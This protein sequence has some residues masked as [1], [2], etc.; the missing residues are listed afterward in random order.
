MKIFKLTKTQGIGLFVIVTLAAIYLVINF[1]KGEDIF[2]GRTRYYTTYQN[3]EGL[4]E[5]SPVFIRGLKVGKIDHISYDAVKDNFI[6]SFTIG[7]EYAVPANSVVEIYS[8]DLLGGKSIRINFGDTNIL[9]KGGDT[10]MGGIVPDMV[11]MLANEIGPV[12]EELMQLINNM[13]AVLANVNSVLDSNAKNDIAK[14]LDNLSKTLENTKG[15]TGNLNK[16]SPEITAV[17]ENLGKL[18]ASL[19]ESGEDINKSLKNINTITGKLS[20]AD[21]DATISSLK[22]LL[23]KLQDPNGSIG[24]LMTTDSMHNSLDSLVRELN[25]FIEK[26]SE[27]PKKYIKIS[28]F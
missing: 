1:L 5:T 13:N 24:K 4:A 12:K 10:L 8:T 14:T 21:L 19:G 23:D 20:E 22:N 15:I 7:D 25:S 17:V 11:S 3:V 6:V 28:V 27:N 2:N 26:V 16:L 18:S 9:A